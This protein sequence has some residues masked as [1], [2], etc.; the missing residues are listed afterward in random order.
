MKKI[1]TVLALL[2]MFVNCTTFSKDLS[3][4]DNMEDVVFSDTGV[5]SF[6][7]NDYIFIGTLVNDLQKTLEVWSIPDSQGFPQLSSITKIKRNEPISP[8]LI[9]ATNKN[10]INITY[11]YKLL[12]PDGT[13]SKNTHKGL[14]IAKG[15]SSNNLLH[16]ASELLTIIFDETDSFGKHQIHISVFDNK[17]N[18]KFNIGI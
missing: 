2:L 14:E 7:N 15:N 16:E 9:Y 8:F 13:F 11:D 17:I 3:E 5:V 1:L 4:N 10:N 18:N 12:R 6:Q